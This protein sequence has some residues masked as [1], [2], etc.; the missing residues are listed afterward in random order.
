MR[1]E[2]DLRPFFVR[3]EGKNGGVGG[4]FPY[5]VAVKGNDTVYVSSDRDREVVVIDIASLTEG[6]LLAR[7]KLDGNALGM[8]LNA[9]QSKLYVAQDNADQVSVVDTATNKVTRKIDARAPAGVLPGPKYTGVATSAVTLSPDGNTLYAV[10]SG[11]NSIAVIPVTGGR[12]NT[13]T[14][15][16]PTAY[17]PHDITFSADGSQMCIISGKSVTG[18]NPEHLASNTASITSITYPGGNTAAAVAARASNQ[19]QFQLERASLVSAPVPG[20][21]ELHD[22]TD[23]VALNNHY[24]VEANGRDEKAMEFLRKHVKHVIYVVKENRTFDQILGDLS[25]GANAD[26]H[27]DPVRSGPDAEQP[28]DGHAVR[29]A[30]QLHESWRRQHGRL[31]LVAAGTCDHDRSAHATD[32]LRVGQPWAV[33][34]IRGD[35]PERARQSRNRRRAR[36]CGL[37]SRAPTERYSTASATL[38]GGTVNLLTGER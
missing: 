8:T 18:P 19:Y 20:S 30:R 3:N 32:Q 26:P 16:I 35:Q 23:Q 17:E 4:T 37:A 22:L 34:R 2:H 28:P 1:Y 21:H 27:A 14:G 7:I 36:R 6:H 13:V 29:D 33:I 12:A 5:G 15:L 9:T 31:V 24:A 25:N 38:P 10:N 11:A